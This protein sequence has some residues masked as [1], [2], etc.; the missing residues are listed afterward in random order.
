[1][2]RWE[3]EVRSA[4]DLVW[5]V[6]F[7]IAQFFAGVLVFFNIY[8][9][10][11][12]EDALI[13]PVITLWGVLLLISSPLQVIG[14]MKS[15][16]QIEAT[17][18][19]GAALAFGIYGAVILVGSLERGLIALLFF[20][21]ITVGYAYKGWMLNKLAKEKRLMDYGQPPVP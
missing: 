19:V 21:A 4:Y 9:S 15:W 20:A 11:A 10:P 18:C 16:F 13:I 8:V 12:I 2:K 1:M 14:R 3:L 7:S 6:G 17:G 5:S